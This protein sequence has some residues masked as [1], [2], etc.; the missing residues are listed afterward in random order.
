MS[1]YATTTDVERRM[2]DH[3][4]TASTKPSTTDVQAWLDEAE[5]KITATLRA[6][7][8]TTPV[9]DTQG[10]TMLAILATDYGEG[11][12]RR[13]LAFTGGDGDNQDGVALLASFDEALDAMHANPDRTAAV[14]TGG[15]SPTTTRNLRASTNAD[16]EFERSEVW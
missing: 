14:L 12:V 16:P 7:G 8:I 5:A 2:R 11:R 1:I 13:T 9:T 3:E 15:T 6:I 4:I 10:I